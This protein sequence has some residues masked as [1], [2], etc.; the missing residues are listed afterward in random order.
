M[1]SFISIAKSPFP[2]AAEMRWFKIDVL[3]TASALISAGLNNLVSCTTPEEHAKALR[4]VLSPAA[5]VF[6]QNTTQFEAV[7]I[8]WSVLEEPT[9]NIAVVPATED[10]VVQTVSF[11]WVSFPMFHPF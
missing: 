6:L 7:A 9:A 11:V 1:F 5:E 8:R 3:L 2:I 4:D 10:D